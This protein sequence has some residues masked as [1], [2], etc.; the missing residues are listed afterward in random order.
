MEKVM[1]TWGIAV[2]AM[3]MFVLGMIGSLLFDPSLTFILGLLTG[4]VLIVLLN[5]I[6]VY[7]F[8]KHSDDT[9]EDDSF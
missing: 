5:V 1:R 4:A 8:K 7:F 3:M 9:E 6:F 2:I